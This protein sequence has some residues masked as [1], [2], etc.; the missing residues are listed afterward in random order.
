MKKLLE[1]FRDFINQG[2]LIELAVA[3]ILGLAIKSVIDSLV[4][5]V[6]MPVIGAIFGK[7]S[8]DALT[9]KIGDGVIFYGRFL[10]AIVNFLIIAVVIFFMVKIY[11][12]LVSLKGPKAE[13]AK[14]QDE[15]DVLIEIRDLLA[16]QNRQT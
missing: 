2:N 15:K 13:E 4:N 6:V 5:D 9:L 12:K 11:E 7:P 3:F 1:E 10:S 16:Q 14:E 8:F